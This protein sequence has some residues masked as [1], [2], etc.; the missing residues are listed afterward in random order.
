MEDGR[1]SS[2]SIID[3]HLPPRHLR[4]QAHQS[5]ALLYAA[6]NQMTSFYTGSKERYGCVRK[7]TQFGRMLTVL[8]HTKVW[9]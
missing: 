8:M 3:H 9:T 4:Y 7:P 6:R 1:R 5:H 2:T